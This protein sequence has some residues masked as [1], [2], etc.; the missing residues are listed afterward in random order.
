MIAPYFIPFPLSNIS[1]AKVIPVCGEAAGVAKQ[2]WQLMKSKH[3]TPNG[4]MPICSEYWTTTGMMMIM[5]IKL[6]AKLVKIAPTPKAIKI[7]ANGDNPDSGEI[8]ILKEVEI[9]ASGAFI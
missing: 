5:I 4:A 1:L 7:K 2:M 9:P 8:N 3:K 6:V